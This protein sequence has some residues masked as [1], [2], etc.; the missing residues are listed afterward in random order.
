MERV[1]G[2]LDQDAEVLA[3]LQVGLAFQAFFELGK[4]PFDPLPGAIVE[5]RAQVRNVLVE[6]VD[7]HAASPFRREFGKYFENQLRV[8]ITLFDPALVCCQGVTG[9]QNQGRHQCYCSLHRD[10]PPKKCAIA[11][12]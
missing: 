9:H 12:R 1:P 7:T 4:H 3:D 10:P 11:R 8:F 5:S 6:A 2:R